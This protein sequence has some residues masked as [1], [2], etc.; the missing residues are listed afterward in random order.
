MGIGA[1]K[2]QR[3]Y[4]QDEIDL[5]MT[6]SRHAGIAV[7]NAALYQEI[8]GEYERERERT[9]ILQKS[10]LPAEVP[11][12]AGLEIAIFYE[13]ATEAALIGG[14]FYDFIPLY[15]GLTAF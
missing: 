13:S 14:D 4:T 8:K 10:F 2:E 5:L 3:V 15:D 12:V 11:K 9:I 1:L 6:I 7:E